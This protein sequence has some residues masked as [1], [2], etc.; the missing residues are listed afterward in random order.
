MR[1]PLHLRE[2]RLFQALMAFCVIAIVT[3]VQPVLASSRTRLVLSPEAKAIVEANRPELSEASREDL[4][5]RFSSMLY[6]YS[7][8]E[9]EAYPSALRWDTAAGRE[10]VMEE[11]SISPARAVQEVDLLFHALKYGYAA[12]QFFGGDEVFCAAR[13]RMLDEIG[14]HYHDIPF[15]QYSQIIIA[16][17]K[18]IQDGHF[19]FGSRT[20]CEWSTF[21]VSPYL[22]FSLDEDGFFINDGGKRVASVSGQ[23]P[24]SFLKPSIDEDGNIVYV[25]GMLVPEQQV[26]LMCEIEYADGSREIA[27]LVPIISMDYGGAVYELGEIEG[28]P[29]VSCRSFDPDHDEGKALNRFVEDAEKLRQEDVILLDLRSNHGGST[30]Y[31]MLWCQR[32][33][34]G[35]VGP[36]FFTAELATDTSIAL[37]LNGLS[38][39]LGE[40]LS[41]DQAEALWRYWKNA[42]DPDRPGWRRIGIEQGGHISDAPF[43][44]ALVDSN[45]GSATEAFVRRL[46]SLD[47]VVIIG[48]N[49]RGALLCGN[50]GMLVLPYS[51]FEVR[52][53]TMFWLDSEMHNYDGVGYSPDFWVHPDYALERAVKFIRRHLV[54]EGASVSLGG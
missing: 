43:I 38:E 5:A 22:R 6:E 33:T 19:A 18:F 21:R 7:D 17:L 29:L 31:G 30:I 4:L 13:E 37:L 9:D 2:S 23:A 40:E 50:P 32:L 48:T 36:Y 16:N 54:R 35:N 44:V 10:S 34:K 15:W 3:P 11:W 20:L 53:P 1:N 46:R 27:W 8:F 45:A 52:I 26:D 12:Y 39:R 41:S 42:E 51:G 24:S 14:R 49:T 28:F 47:N 25:L